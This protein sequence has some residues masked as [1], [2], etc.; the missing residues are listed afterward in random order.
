MK[1]INLLF[2]LL[3]A[4]V[5]AFG[6]NALT[7][8]AVTDF[9][10]PAYGN[11]GK[12]VI[13]TANQS[14]PD[15][16]IYE[17]GSATNGGGTDSV[18][19]TFPAISVSAGEH[20]LVCR[21]SSALS[22]YFD[23]AMEQFPGALL[24]TRIIENVGSSA[25]GYFPDMNGNDAVELFENGVVIETYGEATHSYGS[26]YASIPWGFRDNW[27]F[28]QGPSTSG[29]HPAFTATSNA[30][31]L[32][33]V[34]AC[35]LGDGNA[36]AAQTLTINV[37]SLP[38]GGANA[39]K[40]KTLLNGTFN[41]SPAIALTLGL[42]TLTVAAPASPWGDRAVK[43]QFDSDAIEFDN[44]TLNGTVVYD[45]WLHGVDNCTDGSPT[46]AQSSCPFP[47]IGSYQGSSSPLSGTT[48]KLVPLNG[49]LAV[50]PTQPEI[51]NGGNNDHGA[52]GLRGCLFDDSIQFNADGTMMHYMDGSTWLEGWQG[53]T[54]EQ[55]G[56]PV[57]PH[58]GGSATWGF[59][60]D[61]LT[62]SGSGAHIGLAKVH[63][64]WRRWNA[65]K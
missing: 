40:L 19:Y 5:F 16:S 3:I 26:S 7:L 62:V 32:K 65:C 50:G 52:V 23:G 33:V 29:T 64:R 9:T 25:T 49:S 12:S 58:D 47:M 1:K 38:T 34:T 39:R 60:N 30:N 59:A 11:T 8:T 31:W 37:T 24:P 36:G 41:F 54:A 46:T 6:Q 57:A 2:S 55:C 13:L 22:N 44:V 53:V 63:N 27:A 42:N 56:A 35:I 15:L 10:T 18:E 51:G 45:Q 28:K 48:W 43:F 4:G 14:I 21:D 17:L 20:I 61:E